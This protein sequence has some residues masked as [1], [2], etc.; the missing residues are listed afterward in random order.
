MFLQIDQ[1]T[2]MNICVKLSVK[3]LFFRKNPFKNISSESVRKSNIYKELKKH[4]VSWLKFERFI[5][6]AVSETLPSKILCRI[7][8][9]L[10]SF[11]LVLVIFND[12]P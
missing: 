8:E 2:Y 9:L 6:F 7:F 10:I 4:P 3:F 11:P 12:L 5:K 1:N